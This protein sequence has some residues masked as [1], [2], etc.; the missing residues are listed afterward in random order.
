L[1]LRLPAR[2]S[3]HQALER[4]RKTVNGG[5]AG[6][7]MP[8]SNR[9]SIRSIMTSCLV[10]RRVSDRQV[11]KLLKSGLEVPLSLDGSCPAASTRAP[12]SAVGTTLLRG[13]REAVG[14]LM[15]LDLRHGGIVHVQPAVMG[16]H[17]VQ[18]EEELD[19]I[20]AGQPRFYASVQ[21]ASWTGP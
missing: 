13:P 19:L 15:R 6:W 10:E 21:P 5:A 3:A 8:T 4:I 9:S 7:W 12:S 17:E 20:A 14:Q 11:R 18:V 2:R 1:L 16:V